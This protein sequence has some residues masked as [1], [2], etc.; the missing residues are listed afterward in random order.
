MQPMSGC[1]DAFG[2]ADNDW[3][4]LDFVGYGIAMENATKRCK[5]AARAVTKKNTQSGVAYGFST[6]LCI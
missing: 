5:K 1:W 3:E 4:M 6:Y 2:D